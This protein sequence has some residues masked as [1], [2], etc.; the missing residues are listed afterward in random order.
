MN[1]NIQCFDFRAARLRVLTDASGDAWFLAKDACDI[2]G[3]KTRDVR[4][5]LDPDE[6][7]NVTTIHIGDFSTVS[8]LDMSNG[9]RAPL[10]ISEPGLYRLIMRSRK[11]EAKD[12]QR[13]LTH[14]VLPALRRTGTY[15]IQPTLPPP[16]PDSREARLAQ[17]VLD[18]RTIMDQ[19]ENRIH[20]QEQRIQTHKS[21]I[22]ELTPKALAFD[23]FTHGP[24]CYD[25][26]DAAQLLSNDR[27]PI[28]RQR[29]VE[30][31]LD[32]HWLTRTRAGRLI[33][34]QDKIDQ[35][36]L[37]RQ[38]TPLHSLNHGSAKTLVTTKGLA[39]LREELDNPM[40]RTLF[41]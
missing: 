28:G 40:E 9:G 11:P 38:A 8:G 10:I 31:M 35:R 12:F 39:R 29:L 20:L 17:A 34:L 23:A 22:R 18:A 6:V 4:K 16:A 25:L 19:L 21:E 5:I 2:L 14:T 36:L 30:W 26:R 13:W 24:E 7:S 41:P 3:T 37:R 15:T 32:H 1:A 27:T 33:P